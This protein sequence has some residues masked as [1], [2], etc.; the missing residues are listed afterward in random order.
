MKAATSLVGSLR[1]RITWRSAAV[2][3]TV[4]VLLL[5]ASER[6][7]AWHDERQRSADGRDATAAATAE[8]NGLVAISSSTSE[9][10]MAALL[11]GATAGFRSELQAQADKLHKALADNKVKATG[12]V[13]SSGLVELTGHQ[14]TVIVAASGTVQNKASKKAE[15]RNYRIEVELKKIDDEWLVSKL[16]FVA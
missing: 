15:P 10:D 1:S 6:A 7:V 11:D 4:L 12:D 8:V 13:V 3:V 14:A 5:F 16:E 9:E 2:A